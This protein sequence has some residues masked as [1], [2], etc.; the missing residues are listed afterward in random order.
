VNIIALIIHF[1]CGCLGGNISGR[2][3][4]NYDLGVFGNS[5]TGILGGYIAGQTLIA[6]GA[7]SGAPDGSLDLASIIGNIASSGMGGGVLMA[8]I[9]WINSLLTKGHR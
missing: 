5:I 8:I 4:K 7:F 1:I 2:L 3:F 9:G 6:L